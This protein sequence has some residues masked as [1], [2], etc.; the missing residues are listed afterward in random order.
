MQDD[1][2]LGREAARSSEA[3]ERRAGGL[4]SCAH[5][6]IVK[7]PLELCVV[8]T[9]Y[10]WMRPCDNVGLW[11]FAEGLCGGAETIWSATECIWR[12]AIVSKPISILQ[13][14]LQ[15]V[16]EFQDG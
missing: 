6:A 4:P 9:K 8:G 16:S 15:S 7:T 1:G 14:K 2:V 12:G 11:H 3:N 10:Q 5:A 13:C